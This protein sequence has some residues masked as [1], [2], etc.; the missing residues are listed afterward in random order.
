MDR[1]RPGIIRAAAAVGI[2]AGLLATGCNSEV[3]TYP[4]HGR[5][6]YKPSNKP[7]TQ[8]G[9]IWLECTKPPCTR[10]SAPL[11]DNGE[12]AINITRECSDSIPGE[13]RA[14]L[15]PGDLGITRAGMAAFLKNVDSKYLAYATSGLK[16][17][18]VP[19]QDNK[20]T[21]YVTK[22]GVE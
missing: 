4:I 16:V 6:I 1:A 7:Y 12:F 5:I 13:H 14:C 22:P 10:L 20:F 18:V 19:D 8:G 9:W 3:P 11:N 2:L 15:Q 21:L 17:T